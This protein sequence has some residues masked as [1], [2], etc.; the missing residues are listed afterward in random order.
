[1]GEA[2]R[3]WKA[4]SPLRPLSGLGKVHH[5]GACAMQTDLAGLGQGLRVGISSQPPEAADLL[6]QAQHLARFWT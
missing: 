1:M 4:P 6:A 5:L 2:Y 3:S